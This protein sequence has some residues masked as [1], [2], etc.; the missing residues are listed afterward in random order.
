MPVGSGP[1]REDRAQLADQHQRRDRPEGGV[2]SERD[3]SRCAAVARRPGRGPTIRAGRHR[4]RLAP[5][6]EVPVRQRGVPW[7]DR[8]DDPSP[9]LPVDERPPDA[10]PVD[11]ASASS[12][13]TPR[14]PRGSPCRLRR[15][16][17]ARRRPAG[18]RR[19]VVS[20]SELRP[21]ES[22]VGGPRRGRRPGRRRAARGSRPRRGRARRADTALSYFVPG[23]LADHHEGGLLRHRAG[24]LAAPR[25]IASVAPSR[26][27]SLQRAG[28]H[29]VRPSS[30]SRARCRPPPAEPDAGGPPLRR[31][32]RGASRRRTTRATASAMVGPTPSTAASSSADGRRDRVDRAELAGQRLRRGRPDVPDRQRRRAPATAGGAWPRPGWSSSRWRVGATARRPCWRRTAPGRQRVGVEGE[33]VAL[34]GDH[35]RTRAARSPPRSRAPRCRSAPRPARWNSRS[36]SWAGQD[37]VLGQRMSTSPS[38]PGASV[39]AAGRAVRRHHERALGA[40]AQLDHRADDLRDHVAGLAQHDG[41]ADQHALALRPR[42]ALCSVAMLDRRRRRRAP[43]P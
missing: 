25:R 26:E 31:R 42:C 35:A 16:R 6:G 30:G 24:D 11:L 2:L 41:V 5:G 37:R 15:Y 38:L 21:R 3:G 22:S 9:G 28:D 34:V 18:P 4:S 13:P 1:G 17:R 23:A 33:Q 32:S 20:A 12:C 10:N 43:A 8:A 36:R 7:P 40:V 39:G 19:G 27:K 14:A 29:D